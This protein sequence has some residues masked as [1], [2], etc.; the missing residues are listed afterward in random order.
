L[1]SGTGSDVG[2]DTIFCNS[3]NIWTIFFLFLFISFF[4]LGDLALLFLFFIFGDLISF[5]F[6]NFVSFFGDLVIFDTFL[7]FLFLLF[8]FLLIL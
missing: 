7:S 4:L 6:V 1:A 3:S 5:I 8:E 2:S